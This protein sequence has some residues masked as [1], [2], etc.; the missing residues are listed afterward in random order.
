VSDQLNLNDLSKDKKFELSVQSETPEDAQARRQEKAE[1]AKHKRRI[2]F[3]SFILSILLLLV[4]VGCCLNVLG[5]GSPDDKKWAA[6]VIGAIASGIG[7]GLMGFA[8]GQKG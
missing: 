1:Q 7:S 8:I 3:W 2:H 5:T 6:G 4:I